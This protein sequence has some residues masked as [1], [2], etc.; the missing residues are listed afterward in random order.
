MI[1]QNLPSIMLLVYESIILKIAINSFVRLES[2]TSESSRTLSKLAKFLFY[3]SFYVF[4][5]PMLGIQVV[6]L[7]KQTV[8]GDYEKWRDELAEGLL[9][10]GQFYSIFLVQKTFISN[11]LSLL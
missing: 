10:S 5:I 2:H 9:Y 8:K 11:G 6:A 3:M 1:G 7:V 4:V